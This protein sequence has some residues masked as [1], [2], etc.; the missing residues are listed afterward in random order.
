MSAL[1]ELK[2]AL[3]HVLGSPPRLSRDSLD[4]IDPLLNRETTLKIIGDVL[5]DS[6]AL[7]II[8]ARSYAHSLGFRKITLL[9]P[10][11]GLSDGTRSTYQVR[12]HLWTPGN[13]NAVALVE[14]KHEHSFDFISRILIG[15][16]E[17]QCYTR[18][19]LTAEEEELLQRVQVRLAELKNEE[20]IAAH[21]GMEALHAVR[22]AQLGSSQARSELIE[23]NQ[24]R[25]LELLAC[26][27]GELTEIANLHGRYQYDP[28]ASKFGGDYVHSLTGTVS[29]IPR[30]V[31]KLQQGD[32]YHHPNQY[33]HRL[34]IPTQENATIIVTTPR[35]SGA[36]GAS[37]Q[38]PTWFTGGEARYPR[39]M[40]T[41]AEL[42]DV[43]TTFKTLLEKH[44]AAPTSRRLDVS[45]TV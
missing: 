9:E 18:H 13:A 17:N 23:F 41:V 11:C 15:E 12:L 4:A 5:E 29:L 2:Q 33:I 42:V 31:L 21:Q 34:Y 16:M 8:A 36:D 24:S 37:F 27:E 26:D 22:L 30:L 38:H 44:T 3:D 40:Y 6:D 39:R 35:T 32:L 43:L 45:H 10:V 28:I 1:S 19:P 20:R 7:K 25:L 14:S